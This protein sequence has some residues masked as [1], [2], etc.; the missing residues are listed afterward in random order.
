[1]NGLITTEIEFMFESARPGVS[2]AVSVVSMLALLVGAA[3]YAVANAMDDSAG[4]PPQESA[5][6][7]PGF[8][9]AGIDGTLIIA[10]GGG[11]PEEGREAFI[12]HAG[13]AEDAR[14]VVIPTASNRADEDHAEEF[15]TT[16]WTDRG[17]QQITMLHTRDR[18]L[19]DDESFV[20]PLRD[21]TGVWVSGGAQARIIAA[22]R[23]TLVHEELHA[24]LKR[25]G[26]IGGT[27]AGAAMMSDPMIERGNPEPEISPGMG[28]L[29]GIIIDQHARQRDRLPRLRNALDRTPGYV[30]LAIDEK[31]ALIVQGTSADVV[32]RAIV[33]EI[34]PA[35]DDNN[36]QQERQLEH[37]DEID[38]FDLSRKAV[39][40]S[41]GLRDN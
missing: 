36:E 32:G 10:G 34:L 24:V 19:A 5:D 8:P 30:G 3:G 16:P 25:G 40:R 26:V 9:D 13:G 38:L 31:T 11:T 28:F 37:G 41:A 1:M 20:E 14:I 4:D 22:Y 39:R 17:V 29:P 35:G 18:D 27:S 7:E 21:A 12:E 23:D 33:T 6:R 2:P 15:Y